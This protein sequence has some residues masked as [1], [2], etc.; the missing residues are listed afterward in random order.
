MSLADIPEDLLA[1]IFGLNLGKNDRQSLALACKRF[2]HVAR[3]YHVFNWFYH[4]VNS[5]HSAIRAAEHRAKFVMFADL[6]SL[7][8]FMREYAASPV[9]WRVYAAKLLGSSTRAHLVELARIFRIDSLSLYSPD[10]EALSD[11]VFS[12]F[13]SLPY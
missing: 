1:R 13:T 12:S 3:E 5:E 10:N 8:H 7:R 11:P 6:D 9:Q 4:H 2:A